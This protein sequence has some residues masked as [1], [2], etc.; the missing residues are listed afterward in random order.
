MSP[1]RNAE[2]G[3]RNAK[4][5]S[6]NGILRPGD[7]LRSG[8]IRI[9]YP[10]G[11]WLT[12]WDGARLAAYIRLGQSDVKFLARAEPSCGIYPELER[13]A[14][15]SLRPSVPSSLPLVRVG[16]GDFTRDLNEEDVR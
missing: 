14:P 16:Q 8:R 5:M 10:K 4:E 6:V 1:T 11:G 3:T 15:S 12:I 13:A 7:V 2:P 9:E